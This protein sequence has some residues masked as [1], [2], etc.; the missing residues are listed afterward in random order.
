MV[1]HIVILSPNSLGVETGI[2]LNVC[3][4]VYDNNIDA[5]YTMHGNVSVCLIES[6]TYKQTLMI[7]NVSYLYH[8]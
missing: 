3:L 2:I 8:T 5:W 1:F 4:Y 7:A 6:I